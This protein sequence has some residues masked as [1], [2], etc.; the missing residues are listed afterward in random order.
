MSRLICTAASCA[1]V[2][3]I[4]FWPAACR[5]IRPTALS[6]LGRLVMAS[7]RVLGCASRTYQL[8]QL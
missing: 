3:K 8:Y 6:S 5:V 7:S 1:M 2:S 4:F